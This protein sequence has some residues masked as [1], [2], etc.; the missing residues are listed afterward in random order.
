MA[1]VKRW[2]TNIYLYPRFKWVGFDHLLWE[3][4][5]HVLWEDAD[6]V[7]GENRG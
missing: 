5:D 6:N 2:L 7:E 4:G 3:E 1:A